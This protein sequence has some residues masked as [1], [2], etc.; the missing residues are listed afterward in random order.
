[1]TEV[2]ETA[3]KKRG[4]YL[5]V[6]PKDKATIGKYASENGVAKALQHFHRGGIEREY[7]ARLEKSNFK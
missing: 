2:E 1:M 7:C 5:K 4:S 3:K 6:S